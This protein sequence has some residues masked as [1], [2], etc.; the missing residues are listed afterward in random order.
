MKVI[1]LKRQA[2]GKLRTAPSPGGAP[3]RGVEPEQG[4]PWRRQ[5]WG[6]VAAV[7]TCLNGPRPSP[8]VPLPLAPAPLS[9]PSPPTGV[10]LR[11]RWWCAPN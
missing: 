5:V 11:A 1:Q 4:L 6:G 3:S 8:G 9:S 7:G 2:D 10:V